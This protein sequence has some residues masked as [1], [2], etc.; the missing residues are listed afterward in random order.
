MKRNFIAQILQREIDRLKQLTNG[1][2]SRNTL[3]GDELKNSV[4]LLTSNALLSLGET[5]SEG[6]FDRLYTS[7]LN[8]IA[9]RTVI[10]MENSISLRGNQRDTWLTKEVKNRIGWNSDDF[11]T[12]RE[13]YFEYLRRI[14]RSEV[15]LDQTRKSSM[16]IIEKLGNPMSDEGFLVKG[17]VVGS[18]QSGKTANFNAVINSSVDMGYQ[19]IIVL[20]GIIEDLRKQ[21]LERIRKE[22]EGPR[23]NGIPVGVGD[24][25]FFSVNDNKRVV[26]QLTSKSNDF[27]KNNLASEY[28]LNDYNI[29]VCKKNVHVLRNIIAW[30]KENI[31]P[32][33]ERLDIPVLIIDDEADNASLNNTQEI[34]D[35]DADP[36]E[37]NKLIRG[38]LNLF[39]QRSYVGYT[40]TP[41]ANILQLIDSPAGSD[42]FE[43]QG[44]QYSFNYEEDLFPEDFIELLN[45]PSNYIGI[46]Q[47]FETRSKFPITIEPLLAR[48]I[49]MTD[50]D[51]VSTFPRRM[52]KDEYGGPLPTASDSR[53]ETRSVTPDDPYPQSLPASLKDAVKSFVLSIAVR[54]QREHI[55][56]IT[57]SQFNN[58]FHTMLVHVSR[59]TIWQNRTRDLIRKYV[60][61]LQTEILNANTNDAIYEDLRRVW[62]VYFEDG[63]RN[64]WTYLPNPNHPDWSEMQRNGIEEYVD[65]YMVE[66]SFDQ[67]LPIIPAAVKN[68]NTVALNTGSRDVLDY[69]EGQERKYIAVGGNRL[70]RG[71]TLEG[72]TITYLLRSAGTADTLMQIGRWFGYRIGYLD[73][74]KLFTSYDLLEK[75][76]ESALIIEDLESKFRDLA[77]SGKTPKDFTLWIRNNPDIIALTR[78]AYLKHVV[79]MALNFTDHVQQG[80]NFR[81]EKER[82]EKSFSDFVSILPNYDWNV[83]PANNGYITAE[84]N[85]KGLLDFINITRTAENFNIYGLPKYLEECRELGGKLSNWTIAIRNVKATEGITYSSDLFNNA[86]PVSIGS[87]VRRST[88]GD[89]G[90]R[91][92][93][94]LLN[95]NVFR[96]KNSTIISPLDFSI[97][98]SDNEKEAAKNDFIDDKIRD[99]MSKSAISRAKAREQAESMAVPDKYYRSKFGDNRGLLMVYL[100]DL[101][102][103][104]ETSRG[105]VDNDINNFFEA[106]G[107]GNLNIPLIGF[108]LGFPTEIEGIENATFVA[109][110]IAKDP[111]TEMGFNELYNFLKDNKADGFD[112]NRNYNLE[113]LRL[114]S[115]ENE[116]CN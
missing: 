36:T 83:L 12:Y 92:R 94:I 80:T 112:E 42:V 62:N 87:T 69:T 108:A 35:P 37:I 2:I 111:C 104:R 4:E 44:V 23:I 113:D 64:I 15:V 78:P 91:M 114:I 20:S 59:F 66:V 88:G 106:N 89:K 28:S 33:A 7:C 10:T 74:C 67:I 39:K 11:D 47:Y 53:P 79:E 99:L 49:D 90:R 81:L 103:I 76:E 96:A 65:P 55:T 110:N 97:I 38:I 109:V 50:D 57:S 32:G 115:R 9:A 51:H 19:L 107:L 46:K 41:F 68:I 13:R 27:D 14:G 84:T 101:Q 8:E 6:E 31:L 17:M 60:E 100:I 70:S 58:R 40:A 30:L 98:L 85:Q 43:K 56:D 54:K 105:V 77:Q 26:K 72:L 86:L 3:R 102:S 73:C 63:V 71:F 116:F 34:D 95:H 1:S 45:P 22:V 48:E 5:F 93:E 61:E 18:V 16:N 75:F 52:I 21:T 82:I 25:Q 24:V 29:L